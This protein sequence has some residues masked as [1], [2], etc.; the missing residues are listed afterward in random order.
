MEVLL[1]GTGSADGW[2]NAFCRCASCA[3]QLDAGVLRT[4]TAAL[5][6]DVLLLDCGPETPRAALRAGRRLDRLEA[7]LLTHAHPDHSAPMALLSRAW[8]HRCEPLVVAGPAEVVEQWR[9]WTPADTP[10]R[11]RPVEAGDRVRVGPYVAHALAAD[12][13]GAAVLWLVTDA[14]GHRLLYA[15]DTGPLPE[16]T[17]TALSGTALDLLLL[18]ETFGD[19]A[20]HRTRHLD[21]PGFGADL[22]RLRRAGA[23]DDGTRVVAVHLGHHNPPD[24]ELGRRLAA[25]GATAGRDGEVVTAGQAPR[26]P[27]P[28]RR[29]LVLGGARSGKSTAAERLLAA[30]PAV[31]Y[32]ATGPPPDG[33]DDD[34]AARVRHHRQRRPAAWR[35]V[36]TT[37]LA[38]ALRSATT[39]LLVDCLG[40]W[41]TAV[42]TD[43][44]AWDDAP[45][46]EEQAQ[47]AVDEL[48]AAW[49]E[50][51]VPL[52]AVSNE[53]GSG[54]VP[55]HPSGAIFRDWLG[56]LNQRVAAAS[57][58]RLLVVAGRTVD[59]P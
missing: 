49:R 40:T 39:P 48:L 26:R 7:V 10:V 25:W 6:D 13:D 37:D 53:V 31:T 20:A 32:V 28:P 54:V 2:P 55:S 17:V 9:R 15:T 5:V 8:A 3:A 34:W 30:E 16:E 4:P 19:H 58:R 38:A 41:L 35:T 18:E 51:T 59:L 14:G 56:R 29:T 22:A 42:L 21:L 11:W 12:H 44:G 27:S 36:E 46:W 47:D 23:V 57:E 43:A 45:G 24:A 1:L 33:A 50:V 52:V